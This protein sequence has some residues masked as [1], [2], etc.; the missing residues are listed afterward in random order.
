MKR[1]LSNPLLGWTVIVVVF[2][3]VSIAGVAVGR[4]DFPIVFAPLACAAAINILTFVSAAAL[5]ET[6][7]FRIQWLTLIAGALVYL[8]AEELHLSWSRDLGIVGITWLLVQGFPSSLL[9]LVVLQIQGPFE[10]D[11]EIALGLAEAALCLTVLPYIQ[12]FVLLPKNFQE[13]RKAIPSDPSAAAAPGLPP[14]R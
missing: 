6:R 10:S 7:Q 12:T 4:D 5:G 9:F 3:I 8:M 14:G 2:L 1:H 11:L 13:R